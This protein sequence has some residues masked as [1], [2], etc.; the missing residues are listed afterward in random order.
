MTG[1]NPSTDSTPRRSRRGR[2][3]LSAV[4]ALLLVV[5][6]PPFINLGRF[7]RHIAASI[8]GSV[9]RPVHIDGVG[10]QLLPVPALTLE[11][12]VVSEDPRFGNEPIL[13]ANEVRA[14]L[15]LRSLWRGHLECAT[16]ALDSPS[17]N[18]VRAQDG[19]WNFDS[20]VLQAE[21]VHT[22]PTGASSAGPTPR[23]PY[24]EATQARINFKRG[25]EKLPF[26][27]TEAKLTFWLSRD[28]TL[29]MRLEAR[30]L[31]TDMNATDTGLVEVEGDFH[32][33]DSL[34]N[35]PLELSGRWRRAQLGDVSHMLL[36]EDAGW[37]GTLDGEG[38]LSGRLGDAQAHISLKFDEIR[39]TDFVP[40]NNLRLNLEC[41]AEALREQ[42]AVR[43][44]HC[45]LPIGKGQLLLEGSVEGVR[46]HPQPTLALTVARINAADALEIARHAT[47]RI[48]QGLAVEGVADGIFQYAANTDGRPHWQGEVTMPSLSLHVPGIERPLVAEVLHLHT[49]PAPTSRR[50]AAQTDGAVLDP[51]TLPLGGTSPAAIDGALHAHSFTLHV[52]GSVLQSQMEALAN[53][54]PQLGDGMD[55]VLPQ[56]ATDQPIAFDATAIRS[57]S[58]IGLSTGSGPLN[59]SAESWTAAHAARGARHSR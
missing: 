41:S 50:H 43:N 9:G 4:I 6:L 10:F 11:N 5:L 3:I 44:L 48:A 40:E 17:V 30:P 15:R 37:R 51:F 38:S 52:R 59:Q 46:Q 1:T 18:L 23:F 7:R 39:R 34:N 8:S 25:A 57:W 53:A 29:H 27:L 47:N 21:Q 20:V 14:T 13:R 49:P 12:F 28:K 54:L 58:G 26:S 32:R 2:W 19:E 56:T 31:R 45:N 36:G 33:A 55:S 16:I 22:T 42:D 24:V 35:I